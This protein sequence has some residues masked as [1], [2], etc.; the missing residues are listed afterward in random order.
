MCYLNWD[1]VV[2]QNLTQFQ[3]LQQSIKQVSKMLG[4][5]SRLCRLTYML[6]A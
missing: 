4:A 1:N 3:I 5:I 2:A 6:L